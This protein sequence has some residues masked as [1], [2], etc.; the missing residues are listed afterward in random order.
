MNEAI[1]AARTT[2]AHRPALC[3]AR[4]RHPLYR[5]SGIG[6][7]G[8][9]PAHWPLLRLKYLAVVRPSN[10][11]KKTA[12]GQT[13]VRLCNYV[14]VYNNDRIAEGLDFMRATATGEQIRAFELRADDVLI[15]KDSESW[16]DIA[17]PAHVPSD[18]PG[19]VCGYHLALLRPRD[20]RLRGD[21]LFWLLA[22]RRINHQFAIAANGVTRHGLST[23]AIAGAWLPCPSLR[24]QRAIAH[25]LA[26]ETAKLDALIARKRHLIE[27][28]QEK[29][30]ALISRVVTQGLDPCAPTKNPDIDW[31]GRVPAHWDVIRLGLLARVSNGTTPKRSEEQYWQ[32][33]TVPWLSSSQVNDY[34]VTAAV[35]LI[36]ETAMAE[37]HLNLLPA[38]AVLVGL[39]GEGRTRG[40]SARMAIDACINQNLAAIVPRSERLNTR[41]LHL[42]LQHCYEPLRNLA[43][44]GNQGALNCDILA[45]LKVLVPPGPEQEAIADSIDAWDATHAALRGALQRHI[46]LLNE[47]R[48]AL[49][50]AA[51]TGQIDVR[52]EVPA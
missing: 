30:V 9:V 20:D 10:V 13:E 46:D 11:D 51:V 1:S 21:Y 15:T 40:M 39:V 44:G 31:F 25:F 47:H 24:E 23:G 41:Y 26:G 14:D 12:D 4:R 33:G 17:V 42:L 52:D 28:L 16:T 18:L 7:L 2:R 38:G 50:T 22:S 35:E 49:I 43:R 8:Q 48:H 5:D 36:T 32:N 6:W 27:L 37:S 3:R 45:G 34:V 19:V 29:R